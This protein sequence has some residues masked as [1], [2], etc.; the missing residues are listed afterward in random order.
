MALNEMLHEYYSISYPPLTTSLPGDQAASPARKESVS[1]LASPS[2]KASAVATPSKT[3]TNTVWPKNFAPSNLKKKNN[4]LR[5]YSLLYQLWTCYWQAIS[6]AASFGQIWDVDKLGGSST[7]PSPK[8]YKISLCCFQPQITIGGF[9]SAPCGLSFCSKYLCVIFFS[10]L[11]S[12]FI[13]G[14]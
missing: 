12:L 13:S 7:H 3:S 8:M 11:P 9:T 2:R 10:A 14:T 4:N 1:S 6:L 5:K